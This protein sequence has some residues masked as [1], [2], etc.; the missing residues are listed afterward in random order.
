MEAKFGALE[1]KG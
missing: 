1:K